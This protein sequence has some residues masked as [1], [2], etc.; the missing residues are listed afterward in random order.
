MKFIISLLLFF[1]WFLSAAE[2]SPGKTNPSDIRIVPVQSTPQADNVQIFITFPTDSQIVYNPVKLQ[3]RLAGFPL[4]TMSDFQRKKEL[5]NDRFGQS[6]R[7]IIDN[8]PY[9]SIY[10]SFV[11]DLDDNTL[12]YDRTLNTTIPYRLRPGMHAMRVFPVRSYGEALK[13]SGCFAASI[14][15]IDEEMNNLKVNLEQPYLTYNEP[16]GEVVY[17]KNQPILLDF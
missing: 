3:F 16:S 11:D 14:F 2:L 10:K 13:G 5:I 6:L 12:Y 4:G 7:I 17:P 8:L 15:Y 9:I 1:P